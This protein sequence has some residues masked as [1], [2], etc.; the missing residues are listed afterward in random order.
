VRTIVS[1]VLEEEAQQ[2]KI[3]PRTSSNTNKTVD[4]PTARI[5]YSGVTKNV[6]ATEKK[7]HHREH[8]QQQQQQQQQPPLIFI[9]LCLFLMYL[10]FEPFKSVFMLAVHLFQSCLTIGVVSYVYANAPKLLNMFNASSS[11]EV[12]PSTS[13]SSSVVVAAAAAASTMGNNYDENKRMSTNTL[14]RKIVQSARRIELTIFSFIVCVGVIWGGFG[15]AF[16][17]LLVLGAIHSFYDSRYALFEPALI[18]STAITT[19]L[20]VV[21]SVLGKTSLVLLLVVLI[22]TLVKTKPTEE[23]V[24]SEMIAKLDAYR[25]EARAK[26]APVSSTYRFAIT[27]I[28]SFVKQVV[29]SAK[30]SVQFESRD[31]IIGVVGTTPS[32]PQIVAIGALGCVFIVPLYERRSGKET[33]FGFSLFCR[34]QISALLQTTSDL[35]VEELV[36]QLSGEWSQMDASEKYAY[37]LQAKDAIV[38]YVQ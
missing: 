30:V 5:K 2:G 4:R 29:A 35:N 28:S 37:L 3:T 9:L 20:H 15:L 21:L 12:S 19:F 13:S 6:V 22:V 27:R 17:L 16:E 14:N 7:K 38:D 23:Q 31:W 33:E 34:E 25:Q 1:E 10:C 24:R 36:K 11:K 18:V 26:A 8:H 32:L